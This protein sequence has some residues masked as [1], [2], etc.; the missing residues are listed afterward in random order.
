MLRAGLGKAEGGPGTVQLQLCQFQELPQQT[1]LW[2]AR[3]RQIWPSA[4]VFRIA[5]CGL[6]FG[7]GTGSV[8]A[9]SSI[10]PHSGF[11]LPYIN[12]RQLVIDRVPEYDPAG[13]TAYGTFLKRGTS[14]CTAW[15]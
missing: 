4:L 7:G 11:L 13:A 10:A 9:C 12:K 14:D 1:R 3:Q 6:Q 15:N 2:H 5:D 8:T